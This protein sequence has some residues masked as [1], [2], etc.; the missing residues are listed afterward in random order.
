MN[1]R[2]LS[3]FGVEILR[4]SFDIFTIYFSLG[5]DPIIGHAQDRKIDVDPRAHTR[6][7]LSLG[8]GGSQGAGHGHG[9]FLSGHR[10]FKFYHCFHSCEIVA[11]VY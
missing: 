5:V 1:I 3:F 6:N 8:R 4:I 7:A 2:I 10:E 11:Q 9:E